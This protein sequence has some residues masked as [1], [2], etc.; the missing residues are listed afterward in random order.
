MDFVTEEAK[1]ATIGATAVF[2]AS[3]AV[4]IVSRVA[5]AEPVLYFILLAFVVVPIILMVVGALAAK[6]AYFAC[7]GPNKS[8]ATATVVALISAIAG[9]AV[10]LVAGVAAGS[11]GYIRPYVSS[12]D[13]NGLMELAFLLVVYAVAGAIG[14]RDDQFCVTMP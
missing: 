7:L 3:L 5:P 14:C 11:E 13:F 6:K 1:V 8:V 12:L 2:L 10:W 4:L 9:I